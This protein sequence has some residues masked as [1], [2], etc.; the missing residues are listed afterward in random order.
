MICH[1]CSKPSI[2][3]T[4]GRCVNIISLQIE[5]QHRFNYKPNTA[6]FNQLSQFENHVAAK[7]PPNRVVNWDVIDTL[8][9]G[10][11]I[12]E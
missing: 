8:T 11:I 1:L 7:G 12:H 9:R 2:H 4:C 6:Y 3:D 5:R 10:A